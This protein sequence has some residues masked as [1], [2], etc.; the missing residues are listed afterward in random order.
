M[1]FVMELESA[2]EFHV[3]NATCSTDEA[4]LVLVYF[5]E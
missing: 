3:L 2:S 1:L 5:A 4:A